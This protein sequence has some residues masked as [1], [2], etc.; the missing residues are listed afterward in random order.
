MVIRATEKNKTLDGE[1]PCQGV[2]MRGR[3]SGRPGGS[4]GRSHEDLS[5]G[6]VC[7][8]EGQWRQRLEGRGILGVFED[9]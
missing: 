3:R 7:Q 6:R 5:R 9:Q 4:D 1:R 8:A 2:C